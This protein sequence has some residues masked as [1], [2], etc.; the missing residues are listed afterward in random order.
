M[1]DVTEKGAKKF[2]E[3]VKQLTEFDKLEVFVGVQGDAD[4]DVVEYAQFNEFGTS[5]IPA[6]PF[7][8]SAMDGGRER[9]GKQFETEFAAVAEGK[10]T[11]LV[12]FERLGLFGVQL[13]R[14]RILDAG[15]WAEP[16]AP[17]TVAQKG[18]SA[19]LVDEG[20]LIQ[21][22]TYQVRKGGQVVA[23]GDAR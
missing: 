2:D 1:A 3:V 13:V 16:N 21:S 20:R 10:R 19:P 4:S 8:R 7:M 9:I 15:S 22:L 12:A 23:K 6:R 11:A 17:S 5:T 18:S 14:D